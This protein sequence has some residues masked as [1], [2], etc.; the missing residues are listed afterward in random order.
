MN[1]NDNN[2][3]NNN[4]SNINNNKIIIIINIQ[5]SITVLL[6]VNSS[7]QTQPWHI[8]SLYFYGHILFT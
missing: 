4:N 6:R 5:L 8:R 7:L 2:S 1:N 3:Y